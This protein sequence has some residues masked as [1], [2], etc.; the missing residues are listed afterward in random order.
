[1]KWRFLLSCLSM[2][3]VLLLVVIAAVSAAAENVADPTP[4]F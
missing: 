4:R 1:M 3:L 2:T